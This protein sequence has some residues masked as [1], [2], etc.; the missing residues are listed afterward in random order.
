MKVI[1]TPKRLSG[2]ISAVTS[3]SDAHRLIIAAALAD[4]PTK[5]FM[6][7]FSEDINA[8]ID[9]IKALGGGCEPIS[10]GITV[11]PIGQAAENVVLRCRE[12]G[13]TARFML[14]VAAAVCKNAEVC[15]SARLI[16]RP[17]AELTR[18]LSSHGTEIDRDFLPIKLRGGI[19]G[20][21][22]ALAGNI[23]S[24]YITGLL[25]ALPLVAGGGK[26]CLTTPLESA[27]YVDMT[28]DTL[29]KFG[30]RINV[31]DGFYEVG[32]QKY[33]SPGE[34]FADGDWSNAAF[35]IAA[36]TMGAAVEVGGLSES[37][38][39][40]DKRIIGLLHKNEIDASQIP[41]LV[42]ILATAAAAKKGR[43]VI[44]NAARLRLKES[45]R[46][47]AMCKNLNSIGGEVT[48]TA[49]GLVING[50]GFLLGGEVCGF[51]DHRIVM[52]MAIASIICMDKLAINGAE[53]VK[54]SYPAFFNDFRKLGGVFDVVSDR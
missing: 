27:A 4:K 17:F 3:K 14:P 40:G 52:A 53:A 12:S 1:I 5:I 33:I 28:L 11:S 38:H 25:F 18:V 47:T 43:T 51:N 6:N 19:T 35:W 37:S 26:I 36:N 34:I 23:S 22:F 50:H 21:E 48:E 29:E 32:Q 41:D 45:D 30:V 31:G 42:P 15:G 46:L 54:K 16:E 39:Q 20:G 24:Q 10:D 13:S 7:N 2:K 9:C 44:K 49:D 8:T